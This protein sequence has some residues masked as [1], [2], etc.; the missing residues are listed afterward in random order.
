MVML[1]GRVTHAA[2]RT[3]LNSQEI[4]ARWGFEFH[5]LED[6]FDQ[7]MGEG[8]VDRRLSFV[9]KHRSEPG[10]SLP[11]V[12]SRLSNSSVMDAVDR[13]LAV[14]AAVGAVGVYVL[15]VG[16]YRLFFGPLKDIPG[17]WYTKVS[18]FWLNAHALAFHQCRAIDAVFQSYGPV[19]R[20]GPNKVGFIDA[21]V[22]K[23]VYAK[24]PKEASYLSLRMSGKDHAMTTL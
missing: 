5:E 13:N 3:G 10:P 18:D 15:S 6:S 17:P 14:G 20:L 2:R 4:A 9:R 8:C 11:L 24:F 1:A 21:N 23:T 22:A 12:L 7:V 16:V 19:V